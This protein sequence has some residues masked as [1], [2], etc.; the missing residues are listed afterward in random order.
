MT[1]KQKRREEVLNLLKKGF[2]PK[3]IHT[4][5]GYDKTYIYSLSSRYKKQCVTD[6]EQC[7]TVTDIKQD[8]LKESD[9]YVSKKKDEYSTIRYEM[10]AFY[11]EIANMLKQPQQIIEKNIRNI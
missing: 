9:D 10:Y 7:P 6:E 8:V 4:V 3:D 5:T 2:R 11:E 1:E